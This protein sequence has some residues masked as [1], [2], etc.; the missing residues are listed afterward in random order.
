MTEINPLAE[1]LN[2]TLEQGHPSIAAMLSQR[3]RAIFFPTKGLLAQAA[4]AKAASINATIGI[5]L[6]DDGLPM[7]LPA[8][9]RR[10]DL[11]PRK[12]FPYASSY[13]LAELRK[14]WQV[15]IQKKNPSLSGP[16]SMPVVTS[17]LTH[18]LSMA[19]YL[20]VD[21]GDPLILPSVYWGNYRLVFRQNYG[22]VL[23]TYDP[24]SGNGYNLAGLKQ[25]L[26]ETKGKQI[27]LLNFPHNPTG[28]SLTV[29]EA[30]AICKLLADSAQRGNKVVVLLDDAYFGLV[31]EAGIQRESLFGRLATLHENILAVKIDGATKEDYAWGFRVGFVSFASK[32]ADGPVLKALEDK[33]AGALRSNISSA[34]HLSQSLILEA[35]TDASYDQEKAEK[36]ALMQ[37][38]YEKVQEVLKTHKARFASAFTA[39]PFNSGYFMCL[40]MRD[41]VE[42]ESVRKTL[43]E[44]HGI[45]VIATDNL[46]RIAFS[47]APTDRI[48]DI[49]EAVYQVAKP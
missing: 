12:V 43:L 39:L 47:S 23:K 1:A 18:G 22:A 5:G 36:A 27:V 34:C 16:L 45:G 49:F 10:I 7:R 44:S 32:G 46:V 4:E 41:G 14:A 30:E 31:Y 33:L 20:F 24:F 9:A 40:K 13:G 29:D 21:E 37:R 26:E 17:G 35:L 42:A 11:D 3:G 15:Q 28:Y 8:I 6:D 38:R 19:G 48:P 25:Q 2:R